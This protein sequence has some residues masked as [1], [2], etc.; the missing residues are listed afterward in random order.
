MNISIEVMVKKG[1][2]TKSKYVVNHRVTNKIN[3]RKIITRDAS[4]FSYFSDLNNYGQLIQ[5]GFYN[6]KHWYK[7]T[8][9]F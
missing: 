7:C 4:K 5:L 2:A 8:N 3:S 1:R 6:Y 9:I